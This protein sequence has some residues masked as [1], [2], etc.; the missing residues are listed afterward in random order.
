MYELFHTPAPTTPLELTEERNLIEY[1][2]GDEGFSAGAQLDLLRQY[3]GALQTAAR[4]VQTRVPGMTKEQVEDLE[5]DLV[6]TALDAIRDF[7]LSTH[8]RL[9]QTLPA[10][11]TRKAMDMATALTIPRGV[12]AR[13]FRILRAADGDLGQALAKSTMMGMSPETFTS[14]KFALDFGEADWTTAHTAAGKAVVDEETYR[15]A[16][17]GLNL[18]SDKEREVIELAYGFRGDPKADGE[19]ADIV[20]RPRNTVKFQRTRALEKMRR[21]LTKEVA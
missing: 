17:E 15:L 2:Q 6:L 18:L 1:A 16:H 5:S 8:I 3:A 21:E 9:A 14:I 10:V 20:M 4:L 11:L 13:W 7:N 19:V 12:L